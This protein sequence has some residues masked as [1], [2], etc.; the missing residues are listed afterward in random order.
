M[1]RR[2]DSEYVF[3]SPKGKQLTRGT[4]NYYWRPVYSAFVAKFGKKINVFYGLRHTTATMLLERGGDVQVVAIQ[5][6]HRDHGRLVMDTYGH[7]SEAAARERLK[8]LFDS[9]V[10]ELKEVKKVS[11]Q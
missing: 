8:R 11:S 1:P 3:V 10:A 6:G 2:L 7:P 5:M 9:N 4:I